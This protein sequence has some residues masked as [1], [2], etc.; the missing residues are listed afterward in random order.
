MQ[1][2]YFCAG[3]LGRDQRPADGRGRSQD[4]TFAWYKESDLQL[5]D[6]RPPPPELTRPDPAVAPWVAFRHHFR[7]EW[8]LL[9]EGRLAP[10]AFLARYEGL[11]AGVPGRRRQD[12]EDLFDELIEEYGDVSSSGGIDAHGGRGRPPPMCVAAL[13]GCVGCFGLSSAETVWVTTVGTGGYWAKAKVPAPRPW[14]LATA[15]ESDVAALLRLDV[16]QLFGKAG[17]KKVVA[18]LEEAVERCAAQGSFGWLHVAPLLSTNGAHPDVSSCRDPKAFA[19]AVAVIVSKATVELQA[20]DAREPTPEQESDTAAAK[21]DDSTENERNL[22]L[23]WL[24][25][26]IY[27]WP[28]ISSFASLLKHEAI[29]ERLGEMEGS[30]IRK[31]RNYEFPTKLEVSGLEKVVTST[32]ALQSV[33]VRLAAALLNNKEIDPFT[34]DVLDFVRAVAIHPSVTS[35]AIEDTQLLRSSRELEVVDAAKEWLK[36]NH[37][38]KQAETVIVGTIKWTKS[39]LELLQERTAAMVD[40]MEDVDGLLRT[41]LLQPHTRSLVFEM[42]RCHM[43]KGQP[44]VVLE[45]MCAAVVSSGEFGLHSSKL[46]TVLAEKAK[47]LVKEHISQVLDK[48][49]MIEQCLTMIVKNTRNSSVLREQLLEALAIA[50][51]TPT[52]NDLTQP[53]DLASILLRQPQW[54][55]II[56]CASQESLADTALQS[57][58]ESVDK[59]IREAGVAILDEQIGLRKLHAVLDAKQQYLTLAKQLRLGSDINASLLDQ[60]RHDLDRFSTFLTEISVYVNF[61]CSCGVPIDASA[62]SKTVAT[63]TAQYDDLPFTSVHGAFKDVLIAE[64]APWLF[65]LQSSELFLATWRTS[66]AQVCQDIQDALH[67]KATVFDQP[68]TIVKLLS[69]QVIRDEEEDAA[70]A[71]AAAAEA[72]AETEAEAEPQA[73]DHAMGEDDDHLQ[74][75]LAE[76][77]ELETQLDADDLPD[78][79]AEELEQELEDV[80]GAIAERRLRLAGRPIPRVVI[81]RRSRSIRTSDLRS[82]VRTIALCEFDRVAVFQSGEIT[83]VTED[84]GDTTIEILWDRGHSTSLRAST[85]NQTFTVLTMRDRLMACLKLVKDLGRST[86]EVPAE[87]LTEAMTRI[88]SGALVDPALLQGIADA[89]PAEHELTEVVLTQEQ[90]ATDLMQKAKE[91]WAGLHRG[92][93]QLTLSTAELQRWFHPLKSPQQRESEVRM[94]AST[95][96]GCVDEA[97]SKD[98][99]ITSCLE[100]VE[101]FILC[102]SLK[103]WLPGIVDMRTL[104]ADLFEVEIDRDESMGRLHTFA[105]TM[106]QR[107]SDETLASLSSLIEPVKDMFTGLSGSSSTRM[108][109]FAALSQEPALVCWLLEHADTAA[110]NNLLQVCRPRTEDPLLLKA[111]ASLI[112][113]RTILLDLFYNDPPYISLGHMLERVRRIDM[114]RGTSIEHL[115]NVQQ[116]FPGLLSLFEKTTMGAGISACY[117]LDEIRKVGVFVIKASEVK[118][119]ILMLRLPANDTG[120]GGGGESPV[121]VPRTTD[122]F[123]PLE[124]VQDL[125][126]KLMMTEIPAEVEEEIPD[127]RELIERFSGFIQILAEMRDVMVHLVSGGHFA[128]QGGFSEEYRLDDTTLVEALKSLTQHIQ[129]WESIQAHA[130]ESHFFL[131][132]YT[133]R[134]VLHLI[135]VLQSGYRAGFGTVD[136][137]MLHQS[138]SD[139][140]P[141]Y[142]STETIRTDEDSA[143][144]VRGPAGAASVAP[145]VDDGELA[146]FCAV[147]NQ[148]EDTGLLW[149]SRFE[150]SESA[151]NEFFARGGDLPPAVPFTQTSNSESAAQVPPRKPAFNESPAASI[152]YGFHELLYG[153]SSS[154]SITESITALHRWAIDNHQKDSQKVGETEKGLDR[155]SANEEVDEHEA[156]PTFEHVDSSEVLADLVNEDA[157]D[158]LD[159]LGSLLCRVGSAHSEFR[160]IDPP[161]ETCANRSDMIGVIV[162]TDSN[163][164]TVP[165]WVTCAPSPTYVIDVVLSIYVRRGRLP[166]PGEIVFCTVETSVEQVELLFNRFL[167]AKA[168]RRNDSIFCLADIHTLSYT[169]QCAVTN[170]LQAKLAQFGTQYASSLVIVSG[171]P[172]QVIL[173]SLSHHALDCPPLPT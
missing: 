143:E 5:V 82:G 145:E 79:V 152:I 163:D 154:V 52:C 85:V 114:A 81:Q 95:G 173:N 134:E 139:G 159:A 131:N 13:L 87:Q 34:T 84:D 17:K 142:E 115:Q 42:T 100:K 19:T 45:A 76:Q 132:Y 138:L 130:R 101:E 38:K 149:V 51:S 161:L 28:N 61:F 107:W 94:L 1:R 60:R 86:L 3:C 74:E 21:D 93:V 6:P 80:R 151:I 150:S 97:A 57:L 166:E 25:A 50:M 113:V 46:E 109:L 70:T 78:Q 135:T 47:G 119:E 125:R 117:E 124:Y 171:R 111:I 71:A 96:Q 33:G 20:R 129:K 64:D 27:Y 48:P 49:A 105:E 67:R 121:T 157:A 116:S 32:P 120:G 91:S 144:L 160:Q 103:E 36:R 168:Q 99:W 77:R 170:S 72:E 172:R 141:V 56:H 164:Q 123:E 73:D 31:I 128:F 12:A 148:S 167:M 63:I 40:V 4:K 127:L 7:R 44:S 8:S 53:P 169:R 26:A 146:T 108:D 58:I 165:I 22:G 68:D 153:I 15:L 158:L 39:A 35:D 11:V 30:I 83:G 18:G 29:A 89:Q 136:V 126:S 110:V 24:R 41:E 16:K 75:L 147:T 9:C 133:S 140:L 14:C 102:C 98:L 59:A 65:K 156:T 118:R 2:R 92:M 106:Q 88:M 10:A 162:R 43:F 122:R 66:G 69:E 54:S 155:P 55:T 112:H 137:D 37:G 104:L 62:L 23:E 90:V